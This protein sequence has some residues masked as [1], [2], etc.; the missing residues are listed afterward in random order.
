MKHLKKAS[1]N[2]IILITRNYLNGTCFVGFQAFLPCCR[3]P[4]G[5]YGAEKSGLL[6]FFSEL[7]VEV[8]DVSEGVFI[9]VSSCFDDFAAKNDHEMKVQFAVNYLLQAFLIF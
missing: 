1:V 8:L 6:R 4:I 5:L 3:L 9:P 2:L 7:E